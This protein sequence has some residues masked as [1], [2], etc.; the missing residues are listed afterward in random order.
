[1]PHQLL[2]SA[3]ELLPSFTDVTD[4]T[5]KPQPCASPSSDTLVFQSYSKYDYTLVFKSAKNVELYIWTL[6]AG[7]YTFIGKFQLQIM[8]TC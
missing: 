3:Q 1:M 8:K 2:T 5:K 7:S 6:E 4:S